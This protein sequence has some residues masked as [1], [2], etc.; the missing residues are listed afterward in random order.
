[1]KKHILIKL[2]NKN[3][4]FLQFFLKQI[5]KPISNFYV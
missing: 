2:V 5:L 1:M 3:L 4:V